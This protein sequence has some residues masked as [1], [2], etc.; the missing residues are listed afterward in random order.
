MIRR[1][2]PLLALLAAILVNLGYWAFEGR[3]QPVPD[4]G[5][6]V[7]DSIS[8]SPYLRGYS[9][10]E[11]KPVNLDDMEKAVE[12]LSGRV[13]GLR[14]YSSLSGQEATAR[15]ARPYGMKVMQGAWIGRSPDDNEREIDSL[16]NLANRYPDVIDRVI[17]GNE[18]LLRRDLTPDQLAGSGGGA[19]SLT[20][21]RSQLRP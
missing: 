17:V 6:A 15:I 21:I 1:V 10:Y 18:V 13:N 9:P 12:T 5:S 3:E 14:V 8:F 19:A 2:N 7:I 20:Q 16:I 4:A 11:K